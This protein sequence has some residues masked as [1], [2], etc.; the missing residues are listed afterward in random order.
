MIIAVSDVHL[1]EDKYQEQDGQ[2][3]SFL[4]YVRDG[5]LKDGGHFVLLGDIFD[6]WRKDSVDIL[7]DYDEIIAKLM[8]FPNKVKVHYIIGNH[9]YYISEIPEY[10]NEK[11]FSDFGMS[12]E[13]KDKECFRFIH[14][15]QLEVMANPYTKDMELYESL[16]KRLSYHP[17]ITDH[18]ADGIWHAITSITQHEGEYISSMLKNPSSRL[19]GEHKS[20]DKIGLIAE[21][22]VREL[23]LGGTF[24]WLVYGHTHHPYCDKKSKTINTG[25]WGRNQDQTKMCYLKIEDGSPELVPWAPQQK[26]GG[27]K[28]GG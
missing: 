14:G 5:L 2:F 12:A 1:G 16:A 13:I 19:V 3:S 23:F 27:R 21:S 9:D 26:K 24:D 17:A 25:S 10:F 11:P 15:Y 22:K 18:L 7:N 4:D 6:F 28:K 8:S 20:G